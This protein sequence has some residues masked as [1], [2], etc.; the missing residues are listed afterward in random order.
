MAHN[1]II[2]QRRD[3]NYHRKAYNRMLVILKP[4]HTD[5]IQHTHEYTN[6]SPGDTPWTNIFPFDRWIMHTKDNKRHRD[7]DVGEHRRQHFQTIQFRTNRGIE[8]LSGADGVT[9]G[10]AKDV[11]NIGGISVRQ[12]GPKRWI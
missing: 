8:I 6:H 5:N 3:R 11:G 12:L 9:H 10:G 2:I 4:C 7:G 1:E